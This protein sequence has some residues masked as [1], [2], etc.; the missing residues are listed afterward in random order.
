MTR[1]QHERN[2]FILDQLAAEGEVSVSTLAVELDVSPVTVRSTLKQLEEDGYL[3]RTH[4]GA[5]PTAFRN[6]RLRQMDRVDAKERIVRA[7]A[8]MVRDNDRIMIEAGTTCAMIVRHLAGNA[9]C[10]L[11]PTRCLFSPTLARIHSSTSR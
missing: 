11:S 2:S 10:R 5:R 7:A 3:V 4:G 1:A 8:A 9:A 6:I